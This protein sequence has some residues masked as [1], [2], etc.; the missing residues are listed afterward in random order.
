MPAASS[1]PGSHLP[2]KKPKKKK[3]NPPNIGGAIKG[4]GHSATKAGGGKPSKKEREAA[5]KA[6]A[7]VVKANIAVAK[8]VS[9]TKPSKMKKGYYTRQ[10]S[11][12]KASGDSLTTEDR[13]QL[14]KVRELNREYEESSIV[15]KVLLPPAGVSAGDAPFVGKIGSPSNVYNAIKGIV[16]GGEKRAAV[17]A[18]ESG[19]AKALPSAAKGAKAE[20]KLSKA[21]AK[22]ER[23]NAA[24]RAG[25]AVR[26]AP[27]K[28]ARGVS[29]R[30][31]YAAKPKGWEVSSKAG[32]AAKARRLSNKGAWYVGSAGGTAVAGGG[33][34]VINSADATIEDGKLNLKPLQTTARALKA[35]PGALA[36]DVAAVATGHPDKVAEETKALYDAYAKLMDSDPEVAKKVIND[37]LGYV[38]I[39][40]G[41]LGLART[42]K[43]LFPEKGV[44]KLPLRTRRAMNKAAKEGNDVVSG[45]HL[46]EGKIREL[47]DRNRVAQQA[48]VVEPRARG[49]MTRNVKD[50]GGKNLRKLRRK[51]VGSNGVKGSDVIAFVAETGTPRNSAKGAAFIRDHVLPS[52]D[53]TRRPDTNEITPSNVADAILEDPKILDSP[54]LAKA[55]EGL[56]TAQESVDARIAAKEGADMPNGAAEVTQARVLGVPTREERIPP[57]VRDLKNSKGEPM[58]KARPGQNATKVIKGEARQRLNRAKRLE[59]QA[60]AL[61]NT[62]LDRSIVLEWRA[63]Q[64]RAQAEQLTASVSKWDM[65][66]NMDRIASRLKRGQDVP[67]QYRDLDPDEVQAAADKLKADAEAMRREALSDSETI[68]NETSSALESARAATGAEPPVFI[69]GQDASRA[70]PVKGSTDVPWTAGSAGAKAKLREGKLWQGDASRLGGDATIQGLMRTELALSRETFHREYFTEF[71]YRPD[72][73]N[74]KA[75]TE[76]EIRSMKRDGTYPAGYTPVGLHEVN[77]PF[78]KGRWSEAAGLTDSPM[79]AMLR[80]ARGLEGKKYVLVP[81]ASWDEFKLQSERVNGL[82]RGVGK[83]TRGSAIALLGYNP[84]WFIMQLGASPMALWASHPNIAKWVKAAREVY[85]AHK[86]DTTREWEN[87]QSKYGATSSAQFDMRNFDSVGMNPNEV[88]NFKNAAKTARMTWAGK[89][90][91]VLKEGPFVVGNRK[92][93][94]WVRDIGAM[95]EMDRMIAE[96]RRPQFHRYAH[97]VADLHES[98]WAQIKQMDG[99]SPSERVKFLN[100]EKGQFAAR[101]MQRRVDDAIGNWSAMTHAERQ[102]AAVLMFYPFLRFS[103]RWAM[104]AFPKNRP[105]TYA[106]ALNASQANAMQ[107]DQLTQEGSQAKTP[108][109]STAYGQIPITDNFG[110]DL[111]RM[112]PAS[113]AITDILTGDRGPL[114]SVTAPFTPAVGITASALAG[115]DPFTGEPTDQ[116]IAQ[117]VGEG[118]ANLVPAARPFIDEQSPYSKLIRAIKGLPTSEPAKSLYP[119]VAYDPQREAEAQHVQQDLMGVAFGPI[120]SPDDPNRELSRADINEWYDPSQR[121]KLMR[122]YNEKVKAK[123]ELIAQFDKY[124]IAAP[125]TLDPGTFFD[126]P[127]GGLNK[128][129]REYPNRDTYLDP[130]KKRRFENSSRRYIGS[131]GGGAIDFGGGSS[132]AL[133][134]SNS[135]SEA[136]DFSGG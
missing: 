120:Y 93:E 70:I 114:Q 103:I 69:K 33:A 127:I 37:D 38:P 2:K 13:E 121:L 100:S 106:A 124:G 109:W 3:Y 20:A 55:I 84:V 12:K 30:A 59:A 58:L 122:K 21:I 47:K 134:F 32:R 52:I 125:D 78:Q 118:F 126:F 14:R 131:S 81:K 43:T 1:A 115:Q 96:A 133:D 82:L 98:V 85:Q 113:N 63:K 77:G 11:G 54:E 108:G 62:N 72:G 4:A 35:M 40:T 73:V 68:A 110:V 42:G 90:L 123:R 95:L 79:H 29:K 46:T 24:S 112:N 89:A 129:T 119:A 66:A 36:A 128:E 31:K 10:L 48:A 41:A 7:A 50:I 105:L 5:A 117:T 61:K 104:Y 17:K 130:K 25:R 94:G 111:S 83:L 45:E 44:S 67:K 116:S 64:Y 9:T 97:S 101:E 53:R 135:G 136:L 107:V 57:S 26:G 6:H 132:D 91:Q 22:A 27:G 99:M 88:R 75:F 87:F 71:T 18:A 15:K 8:A 16:T 56:R 23:G 65:A 34:A 60:V 102:A 92:Y 51:K 80:D 86:G 74:P 76:A 39:I 19:T 49:S 28:A